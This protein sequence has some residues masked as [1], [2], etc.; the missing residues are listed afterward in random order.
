[1]QGQNKTFQKISSKMKYLNLLSSAARYNCIQVFMKFMKFKAI[2][3]LCWVT[4]SDG[5]DH[6]VEEESLVQ[7]L[8]TGLV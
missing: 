1:M 5:Y 4:S 3:S 7:D 2:P 8:R 6:T